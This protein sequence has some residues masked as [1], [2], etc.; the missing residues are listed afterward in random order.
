M[1]NEAGKGD[2]PR[3]LAVTQE[4]FYNNWD[5]IFKTNTLNP[6]C[7]TEGSTVSDEASNSSTCK[8]GKIH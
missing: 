5:D 1:A 6:E 3:P 2:K 7:N 8:C 4:E